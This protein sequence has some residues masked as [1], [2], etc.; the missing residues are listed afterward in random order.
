MYQATSKSLD[1]WSGALNLQGSL[2]YG[3]SWRMSISSE[4][5]SSP[6]W[7]PKI[8][9]LFWLLSV[10]QCQIFEEEWLLIR[11]QSTSFVLQ[12]KRTLGNGTPLNKKKNVVTCDPILTNGMH[13]SLLRLWGLY[14]KDSFHLHSTRS[15]TSSMSDVA[16]PRLW[17]SCSW[18]KL[19]ADFGRSSVSNITRG[20]KVETCIDGLLNND[21][22]TKKL[23]TKTTHCA[24]THRG[25]LD[26]FL[27]ASSLSL[28]CLLCSTM[29]KFSNTDVSNLFT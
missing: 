14:Q 19:D 7:N 27:F 18:L 11:S 8:N 10:C 16:S 4:F 12:I 25:L 5:E 1:R 13:C 3:C 17:S 24:H 20:A 9:C 2:F 29:V 6:R 23:D 22:C 28:P 15:K 21:N 26:G